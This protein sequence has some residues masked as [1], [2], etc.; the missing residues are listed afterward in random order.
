M[1]AK[2]RRLHALGKMAIA[3]GMRPLANYVML[4]TGRE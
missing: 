2:S 1:S 4:A 3:G